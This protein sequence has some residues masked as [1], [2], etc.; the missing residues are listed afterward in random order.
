MKQFLSPD[1]FARQLD[2]RDHI[3]IINASSDVNKDVKK[4]D[5]ARQTAV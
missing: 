4:L 3:A 5:D 2:Q 1:N